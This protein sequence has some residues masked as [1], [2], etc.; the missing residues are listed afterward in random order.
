MIS[1]TRRLRATATRWASGR[2]D[3]DL[4]SDTGS[5]GGSRHRCQYCDE[6]GKRCAGVD[7]VADSSEPK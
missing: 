3:R 1:I 6:G 7:R 5:L 2:V 4:G